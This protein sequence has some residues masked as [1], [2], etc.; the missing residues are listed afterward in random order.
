MLAAGS[1]LEIA[2]ACREEKLPNCTCK[3][4]GENGAFNGLVKT[5]Q[6]SYDPVK[7]KQIVNEFL[8]DNDNPG[9]GTEISEKRKLEIR[10]HNVGLQVGS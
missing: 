10:N 7:G 1:G 4:E 9:I 6:C 2:S 5:Y 3:I 8:Q